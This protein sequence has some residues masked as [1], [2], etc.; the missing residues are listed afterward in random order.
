MN[1]TIC[2][3]IT[4]RTCLQVVYDGFTR[5]VEPHTYGVTRKDKECVRV[6]QVSGGSESGEYTGWKMMSVEK[7][8]R[9][10]PTNTPSQAP[11]PQYERGDSHMAHIYCEI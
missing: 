1:Q 6:W 4:S 7:I 5:L 11:R 2:A 9:I 10:V 8:E 3:A